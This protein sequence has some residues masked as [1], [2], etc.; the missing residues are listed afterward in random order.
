MTMRNILIGLGA[1]LAAALLF[2]GIATGTSLALPLYFLSPLPIA[3]AGLGF[4][5]WAGA[6]AAATAAVLIAA[7]FG[8]LFGGVQL[9]MFG[10][11]VAWGAHLVGLSRPADDDG[12]V[13]WFPLSQ[14]LV[15]VAVVVAAGVV[16]LMPLMGM[17]P[18]NF[19][20]QLMA[21]IEEWMQSGGEPLDAATRAEAAQVIDI[22]VALL[23]AIS[24]FSALTFTV[25]NLWLGGHVARMSGHLPRPWMP[26]WTVT[27]PKHAVT[28]LGIAV[29]AAFVLPDIGS[30][31]AVA[32]AGAFTLAFALSGYGALHALLR[33]RPGRVALLILVYATSFIFA[34]AIIA[35]ALLGIADSLLQFRF[36]SSGGTGPAS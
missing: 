16:V 18:A 10:I 14:V 28:V 4:G 6:A 12:K 1:G 5:T 34:P 8:P 32:L 11:P 13:E 31:I 27:L 22:M 9:A 35:A 21:A 15:R 20:K 29:L 24:A 26:M 19:S 33:G 25:M 3:I 2:A 30:Q 17:N 23:P 7:L 36:R